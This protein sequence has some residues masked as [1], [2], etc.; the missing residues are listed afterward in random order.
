MHIYSII[1]KNKLLGVVYRYKNISKKRKDISPIS[2]YLQVSSQKYKKNDSINPHVHLKNKR[3][4]LSTQEAWIVLKGRISVKIF[5]TDKKKIKNFIL[6][7]GDVYI[8]FR[9][10]HSLKV[11]SNNTEFYEIKNGPYK[12]KIKDIEYLKY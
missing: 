1:K 9:G 5:D 11:L 7:K 10:G 3:T 12:K 4:T 8:L 2:E 6:N